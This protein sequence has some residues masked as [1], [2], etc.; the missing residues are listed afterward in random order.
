MRQLEHA[1]FDG[2]GT[3]AISCP[4]SWTEGNHLDHFPY[5]KI[6]THRER[7]RAK[8]QMTLDHDAI[9]CW[10]NFGALL[11]A[12]GQ[13]AADTRMLWSVQQQQAWGDYTS[14]LQ[15]HIWNL[16]NTRGV[17][18]GGDLGRHVLGVTGEFVSSTLMHTLLRDLDCPTDRLDLLRF[19]PAMHSFHLVQGFTVHPTQQQTLTLRRRKKSVEY[20]HLLL[21]GKHAEQLWFMDTTTSFE[22]LDRKIHNDHALLNSLQRAYGKQERRDKSVHPTQVRLILPHI[23]ENMASTEMEKF[24]GQE[25]LIVHLPLLK[26]THRLA[27]EALGQAGYPGEIGDYRS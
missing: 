23:H 17:R 4:R 24:R 15:S 5:A 20:D 14:F 26:E 7:S 25:R 16:I 12:Y 13:Y 21:Q 9:A 18:P 2:H 1:F 11:A 8:L 27:C 6:D 3:A 10:E 22:W 19:A